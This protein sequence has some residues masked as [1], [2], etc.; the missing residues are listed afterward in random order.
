MNDS[1]ISFRSPIDSHPRGLPT[2]NLLQ[3]DEIAEKPPHLKKSKVLLHQDNAPC[4]KSVKT[5]AKSMKWASNCSFI[6]RIFQ[7]WPPG[8]I[9]CSL[10]SR[11]LA[12]KKYSSNE[13]VIAETKAY[14]EASD[15]SYSTN[16]ELEGE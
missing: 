9:S 15:K 6:H 16:R 5:M 2:M 13:E 4:H 1:I 14:F 12:G 7:I 3:C 10:I 11:L 8:A